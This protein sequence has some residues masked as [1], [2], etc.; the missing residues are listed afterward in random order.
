MELIDIRLAVTDLV[1][2]VQN[3]TASL[4]LFAYLSEGLFLVYCLKR[5]FV[6]RTDSFVIGILS[7]LIYLAIIS[8]PWQTFSVS[9]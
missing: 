7:V 4:T 9:D 1:W 6:P 2:V 8:T 3:L 5:T